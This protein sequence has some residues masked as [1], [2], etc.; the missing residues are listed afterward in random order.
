MASQP[1]PAAMMTF[2]MRIVGA[3]RI[4]A[5]WCDWARRNSVELL[6]MFPVDV[7]LLRTAAGQW[8]GGVL[9]SS[10]VK[11]NFWVGGAMRLASYALSRA[12]KPLVDGQGMHRLAG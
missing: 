8:K 10:A 6:L 12:A 11:L 1:T 4:A 2:W 7:L 3:R 9:L 5:T